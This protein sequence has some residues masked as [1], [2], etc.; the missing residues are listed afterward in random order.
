MF[1]KKQLIVISF[2]LAILFHFIFYF[3]LYG[4]S[5][6]VLKSE[7]IYLL[8]L[9]SSLIMLFVYFG[10]YWRAGLSGKKIVILYDILMLWIF[11]CLVRSLLQFHN[12]GDVREFLFNN[13]LGLSLFPVLF[14]I[15]GVNSSYFFVINKTL[16]IY[17]LIAALIS[18][19]FIDY[20][21]FQLF[22]LLPV[23]Y[24]VVTIPLRTSGRQAYG[25]S[26][27]CEHNNCVIH[28]PGWAFAYIDQL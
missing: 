23:F 10:T 16:S 20:F 2:V 14:F 26:D 1:S 24:I 17:I 12:I 4:P 13:Y 8:P 5:I 19:F 6:S 27:F 18:L 11:V 25:Y 7:V 28:E 21:E 3:N 22:L 15:A 9:V